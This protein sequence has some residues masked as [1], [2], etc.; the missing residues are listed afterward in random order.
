M[1]EVKRAEPPGQGQRGKDPLSWKGVTMGFLL[2]QVQGQ[3][4]L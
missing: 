1:L 2:F 3:G 4:P